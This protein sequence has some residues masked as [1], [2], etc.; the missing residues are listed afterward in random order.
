MNVEDL[1]WQADTWGGVSPRVVDSLVECGHLDLVVQAANERGDWF[2]A[3]AAVRE[4]CALEEFERAWAVMKPFTETNWLPAV[5]AGADILLR[6][7]RVEEALALARPDGATWKAGEV[8]QA[9][10]DVLV[11]AGR[12]DEAITVLEP[13]LMEGWVLPSLVEMTEGQGRDE[14]VLELLVPLA[15]EA[16]RGQAGGRPHALWRALDLQAEV[17]ERSGR[18][19]EAIRILGADVA[20][21]RYGPQ[22]TVQSYAELLA[23]HGRMEELRQAATGG[24]AREAFRPLVMALENAGRAPEGETML[25]EFIDTTDY[26]RNYQSLLMELLARQGRIDEAV[27]A[28]RTTFEDPWEGLLQPAVLMLA[29]NGLHERALRLL[30]ERSPEFLE[31]SLDWVPSNRWLLMGESGRCRE[32]IAEVE[33][34]PGLEPDE[35][36]TTIAWLLAQDGRV[37]EAIDLLR[38]Y[39]ERSIATDLAELL[40]RQNR[41]AEAIAAIPGVA[42]QRRE[43]QRRWGTWSSK[44]DG[45]GCTDEWSSEEASDG[46]AE[47]PPLQRS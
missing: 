44:D 24:H 36:D 15:E 7:G 46:C 41:P 9:Y 39:A 29:E 5:S 43:E 25:R 22:N 6:W 45:A 20:A 11:K 27:E 18:V 34:M 12:V 21:R 3:R 31:E 42:A 28:V 32:A 14:R 19:D 8:C 17:L 23:R 13:H 38:S 30:D 16:R 2:C 4:L 10:A 40:I 26:P 37:D 35:R 47:G 33:A 1:E